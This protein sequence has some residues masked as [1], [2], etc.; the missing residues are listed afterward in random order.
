MMKLELTDDEVR[1][2]LKTLATPTFMVVRGLLEKIHAQALK[3]QQ[4]TQEKNNG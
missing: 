3:E 1:I 4:E 2:V